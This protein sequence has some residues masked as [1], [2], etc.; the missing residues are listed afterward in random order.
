MRFFRP[1]LVCIFSTWTTVRRDKKRHSFGSVQGLGNFCGEVRKRE[2]DSAAV[3]EKEAQKAEL[4][5]DVMA[6]KDL[7][8][9]KTTELLATRE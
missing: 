4:E 1:K 9:R 5:A 6:S 8:K 3:T 7:Q 2:T